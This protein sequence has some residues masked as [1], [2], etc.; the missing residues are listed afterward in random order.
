MTQAVEACP[1]SSERTTVDGSSQTQTTG[2]DAKRRY[3]LFAKGFYTFNFAAGAFLAPYLALYYSDLG[4]SGGQIAK[5]PRMS[6]SRAA[7]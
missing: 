6:G 1:S 3:L 4:L 5:A 7:I 2:A